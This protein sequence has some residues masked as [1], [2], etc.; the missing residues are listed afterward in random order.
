M[1][2]VKP[3]DEIKKGTVE[4]YPSFRVCKSKDLMIRGGDFYAIWDEEN[5]MWS[6]D[7]DTAIRLIDN[8]TSAY[9]SEF[10]KNHPEV[11][12]HANYI[13]NA[14][15]KLID[16]FHHYVQK[17]MKDNYKTLD[18]KLIF[19]NTEV[20]R[21][22]YASHRLDYP[23]EPG[24]HSAFDELMSVLYSDEERQKIE[25]AIGAIVSGDSKKIQKFMV[26]TG[27]AGTGKS[28]V[29]EIIKMLFDGYWATI[30]ARAIG[31]ASAS[32][33]LEALKKNP[34]VAI[35]D[36]ADLSKIQ[37]NTRLNSLISHETLS[38]NEKFRSLYETSYHCFIFLGSNSDVNITDAQSGLLR[39]LIDV[40]PTNKTIPIKRYLE[41][42]EKIK[43]ELGGIAWHCLEVYK[44]N[45]HEYDKY[46]PTQSMRNT[47]IFYNFMEENFFEYKDGVKLSTLWLDYKNFC[48]DAG[49]TNRMTKLQVKKELY[50]YYY[51]FKPEARLDDG[52]HV[53]N[54]F[55]DIRKDKFGMEPTEIDP[56]RIRTKEDSD[57]S[58]SSFLVLKKQK[59][60][61][62]DICSDCPAQ[63]ATTNETPTFKWSN[64]T[65]KLG[66]INT[67][68]LHYVKVPEN[69]IVI[70]FDLKDSNGN[71]S[72]DL[73][74]EA[75]SKWPPTYAEVSKGGNGLHLHYIY[76][77]DPKKLSRIY[78]DDIEIKVFTGDSSLRRKLTKCNDI[79]VAKINSGLPLKGEKP[80]INGEV[81]KSERSLRKLIKRNLNKEIHPN[82]APSVDFIAKILDDA[83]NSGLTYDVTDMRPAILA[84]ANN[85]SHQA[86]KC[87]KTVNNMKFC[88]EKTSENVDAV[89]EEIIFFDVEVFSNLFVVVWKSKDKKPVKMINPTSD[90]IKELCKKR[91]VGFN[92]RKYD[93]H[94]L[95]ARLHDYTNEELY[96]LSQRIIGGS[97]NAMFKEAYNLSYTDIYD[98]CSKK[99]SLK[100]WEIEL[101]IH[102]QEL[103]LKWD[104]PVP[105]NLW[106]KVADYCTNDVIATEA[107]FDARHDD[108]VAREILADI[109]GMTVNDTTNTLTTRIIFGNDKN[110]QSQFFYRDLSQPVKELPQEAIDI[111]KSWGAQIPFDD[112][113]LL[114]YF[115]GYKFEF[116]KSTYRGEEVG[117]GGYVYSEVG[118]YSDV[119]TEDSASHHPSSLWN[120]LHF[121]IEY[122]KRFKDILDTRILIKH[123]DFDAARK[124]FDGKLEKYLEDEGQAAMLAQA[125]KIAINSV[126]GLT[127]AK[128]SNPMKDPR[129]VDNFV[130]KR[131]A[132]FMIDL[133]YAVQEQGF[134]VIHIKTDSIKIENP[135]PEIIQFVRD[136]GKRYGYSFETEDVYERMCLV[137]DAVYIAKYK[138]PHKDKKTGKEVW[139]S[140]T[141]AQF[142]HPYVFKKLFSKEPIEFE[143]LCETKSVSTALYLDMN[144]GKPED[145]HDYV[146]IGKTGSFCPIKDGGG[147]GILLRE[148]DGKYYAATGSKGY[149]WMEAETVKALGKENY[150]NMDYFNKL[151]D[152]SIDSIS[153]Y[154]DFY[155]FVSDEPLDIPKKS[156]PIEDWVN[157]ES[158]KLPF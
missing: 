67:G 62:D 132:L 42:M 88:S 79:P 111:L 105:E 113:S 149:R 147:G 46:K 52:S 2:F 61:F 133:K 123:K 137:N 130:A 106:E 155:K 41:I 117:E 58:E 99:Q 142:A 36:D 90:D 108:F 54:F 22:D 100:K 66:D 7:E 24:D 25:W 81:V 119:D 104:E 98:F 84:F 87:I 97:S 101:G 31:S 154:G 96:R 127:S 128:F 134:R 107:V 63:L 34:L 114:P 38:V 65:T 145:E 5:G 9:A 85:S 20:R 33:A 59:S 35:Q 151:A 75:A 47:N 18:S 126:Y 103:G 146:F 37:D 77:G 158:D 56:S 157:I 153:E 116:G 8:E 57:A 68:K 21:S 44:S 23:L 26:L 50:A 15:S 48:D 29:I 129:N 144:E 53:Y 141:G 136:F 122:T 138:E 102:H 109:A 80:V 124:L 110:P 28:T 51:H 112:K 39:R 27:D 86:N 152:D 115:P 64:V 95:Y 82:T 16:E 71:K 17:Q 60:L 150:I 125:L 1:D 94:I 43:F 93:N 72:L 11:R 76:T 30:D 45:K 70:D 140:A 55:Y 148:K 139:W 6:T 13:R 10:K 12:V 14:K 19:Q 78:D 156:N 73:N 40:R 74:L 120:E 3:V 4:I 92:N 32:F 131:G 121:G 89:D 69:H 49:I 91:L 135:T 143:D 83:Y 118:M